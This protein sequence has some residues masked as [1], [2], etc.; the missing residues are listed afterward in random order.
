MMA[1]SAFPGTD[2]ENAAEVFTPIELPGR[3]QSNRNA[4]LSG[5][6][7]VAHEVDRLQ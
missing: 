3:R 7:C 4:E 6:L 2:P 1:I 5:K